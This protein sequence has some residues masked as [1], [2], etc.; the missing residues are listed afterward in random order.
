MAKIPDK[1]TAKD[2]GI[3]KSTKK[4][5]SVILMPFGLKRTKVVEKKISL[6]RVAALE[7]DE[8]DDEYPPKFRRR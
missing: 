3:E 1:D 8:P 6:A 7:D 4:V 5:R 2:L